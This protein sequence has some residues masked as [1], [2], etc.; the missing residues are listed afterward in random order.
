MIRVYV[1][2]ERNGRRWEPRVDLP[3]YL[4][5]EAASGDARFYA[6]QE[7]SH[8]AVREYKPS[9]GVVFERDR[10]TKP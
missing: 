7:Q 4:T 5:E 9:R 3:L 2:C 1:I 8:L 6:R 10:S